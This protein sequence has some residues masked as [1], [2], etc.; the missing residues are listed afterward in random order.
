[1]QTNTAELQE[2]KQSS[3]EGTGPAFGV[4]KVEAIFV[5]V[6]DYRGQASTTLFPM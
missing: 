6:Y 5:Y 2:I 3:F 1:M 4:A